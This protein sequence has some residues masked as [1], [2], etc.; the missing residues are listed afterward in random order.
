MGPT[1]VKMSTI[2]RGRADQPSPKPNVD[3]APSYARRHVLDP[4]NRQRTVQ[5]AGVV[6]S[7]ESLSSAHRATGVRT[8]CIGSSSKDLVNGRK[9][10]ESL[11]SPW[12]NFLGKPKNC[13]PKTPRGVSRKDVGFGVFCWKK[14][15]KNHMVL[16]IGVE[17]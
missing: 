14:R 6:E 1:A 9:A 2:P 12:A 15:P 16:Y 13:V 17:D 8:H 5:S 3:K 10:G 4:K 7:R 11:K